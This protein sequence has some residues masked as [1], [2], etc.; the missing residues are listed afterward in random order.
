MQYLGTIY[1]TH[2]PAVTRELLNA[3]ALVLITHKAIYQGNSAADPLAVEQE[4]KLMFGRLYWEAPELVPINTNI[5][6]SP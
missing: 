5:T 2:T 4:L 6:L 3:Y 1:S